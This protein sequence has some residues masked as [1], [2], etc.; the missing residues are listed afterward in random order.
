MPNRVRDAGSRLL[1]ADLR[2]RRGH[3]SLR[4]IERLSKSPPFADRVKPLSVTALNSIE[5][6]RQ[7]PTIPTLQ[8]LS[9]QLIDF[10]LRLNGQWS[11]RGK[12]LARA[13]HKWDAGLYQHWFAAMDLF[14]QQNN[15]QAVKEFVDKIYR[16]IGGPLFAGFSMAKQ[17]KS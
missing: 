4:D 17:T 3:R 2:R 11:G 6:G 5:N 14:Y 12:T 15:K 1:G 10:M 7:L 9:A 16:P 8:T 13:L